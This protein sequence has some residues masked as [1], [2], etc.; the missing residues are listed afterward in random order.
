MTHALNSVRVGPGDDPNTDMGPVVDRARAI[1]LDQ[2]VEQAAAHG[3]ILS[4]AAW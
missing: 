4:A 2:L 3:K 1:D